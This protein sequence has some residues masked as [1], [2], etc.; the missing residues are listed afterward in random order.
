MDTFSSASD[1]GAWI[2][3]VLSAAIIVVPLVYIAIQQRRHARRLDGIHTLVNDQM[4]REKAARLDDLRTQKAVLERLLG[5]DMTEAD[6]DMLVQMEHR[7]EQLASEVAKRDD[8]AQRV[9]R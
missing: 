7:I 4:T 3:L 9:K 1:L 2:Y 8:A 6:L 5:D